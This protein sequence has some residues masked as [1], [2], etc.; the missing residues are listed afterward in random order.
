M[1]VG[2]RKAIRFLTE[3]T[4]FTQL[5]SVNFVNAVKNLTVDA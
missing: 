4:E 5:N 1:Y 3:L 2:L